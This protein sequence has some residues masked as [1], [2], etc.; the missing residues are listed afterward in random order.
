[1]IINWIQGGFYDSVIQAAAA[2]GFK[3][4]VE[5]ILQH[6]GD[7][8]LPGGA[9]GTA[10]IAAAFEGHQGIVEYLVQHGA[11]VNLELHF[12]QQQREV[13][14]V[15]LNILSNMGSG[16]ETAIAAAASEGHQD[17]NLQGGLYGTAIAAA[18]FRNAIATSE[19]HKNIIQ[20]L[21]RHGAVLN[22]QD[23]D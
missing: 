14:K 20:Y 11:D 16:F 1:M 9:F 2:K 5:L 19:G 17:I 13:T 12:Q 8:N 21:L 10:I 23:G 18:V 4:I 15:L 3:D 22:L 6:G 7:V